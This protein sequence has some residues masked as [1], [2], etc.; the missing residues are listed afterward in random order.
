MIKDVWS[1]NGI[2]S[3]VVMKK[4]YENKCCVCMYVAESR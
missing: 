4:K 3:I 2:F 1:V